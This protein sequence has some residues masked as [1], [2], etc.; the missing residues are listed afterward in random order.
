LLKTPSF[1]ARPNRPNQIVPAKSARELKRPLPIPRHALQP[2]SVQRATFPRKRG[3]ALIALALVSFLPACE[4]QTRII[5]ENSLLGNLPNAK[6]GGQPDASTDPNAP[7]S[8]STASN[9]SLAAAATELSTASGIPAGELYARNLDGTIQ[10]RAPAIR[11]CMLNLALCLQAGRDELLYEQLI[12]DQT[13]QHFITEGKE[14]RAATLEFL[15]DNYDDLMAIFLRMPA[16]ER[17]PGV[18][19]EKVGPG[20]LKLQLSRANAKG[21]RF[22]ELWFV[23]QRGNW[24]FWWAT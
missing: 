11:H 1:H 24:R 17:S 12:S 15:K 2:V 14:P 4:T 8:G 18:T 5:R 21:L 9:D 10:L 20:E 23:M 22:T 16:G 6:R 19:M 13:K 3:L 7:G